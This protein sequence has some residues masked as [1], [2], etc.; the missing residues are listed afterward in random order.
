[1]KQIKL[2]ELAA[3]IIKRA[4]ELNEKARKEGIAVLKDEINDSNKDRKFYRDIFE[5]GMRLC[6]NGF[7]SD[8]LNKIL[9]NLINLEQN[10]E[11]KRAKIIQKEAVLH[12]QKGH[13]SRLLLNTLISYMNNDEMN[14]VLGFLSGTKVLQEIKNLLEKPSAVQEAADDE[15]VRALWAFDA[16]QEA[17]PLALFD[18]IQN[19]QPLI[20]AFILSLIDPKKAQNIFTKLSAGL[21]SDVAFRIATMDTP[22]FE[23]L[24]DTLNIEKKLLNVSGKKYTPACHQEFKAIL[25]TYLTRE[26][27]INE[28]LNLYEQAEKIQT[29]SRQAIEFINRLSSIIQGSPFDFITTNPFNFLNMLEQEH[30]KTIALIL[31]FLEPKKA[32]MMLENLY[33][34]KPGIVIYYIALLDSNSQDFIRLKNKLSVMFGSDQEVTAGIKKAADL[35]CLVNRKTEDSIIYTLD[36]LDSELAAKVNN[37]MFVFDDIVIFDSKAI[38]NIMRET[39]IDDIKLAIKNAKPEIQEVFLKNMSKRA[40]IMFKED[41]D[42]MKPVSCKETEEAQERIISNIRY[43]ESIGCFI[44]TNPCEDELIY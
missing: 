5:Y 27:T 9:S 6:I 12:I 43:L 41:L 34:N 7:N 40:A 37:A 15:E 30:P 31:T 14:E 10:K 8:S 24:M 25:K 39:C 44:A 3:L 11:D 22:S 19:E 21:Q 32:A 4:Y 28:A 35:I 42:Y 38:H 23:L 1:M 29:G 26:N 18:L 13:N 20:I 16:I 17:D 33:N 2:T 36:K